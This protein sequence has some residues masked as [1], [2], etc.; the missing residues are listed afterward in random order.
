MLVK[1]TPNVPIQKQQPIYSNIS[2]NNNNSNNNICTNNTPPTY[3]QKKITPKTKWHK[4]QK[5]FS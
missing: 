2:N 4:T 3:L 5:K 1:L